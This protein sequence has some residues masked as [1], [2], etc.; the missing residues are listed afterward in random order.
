MTHRDNSDHLRRAATA[1]HDQMLDRA[2]LAVAELDRRGHPV[3]I[4]SVARAAHV[5]RSWL[6]QQGDLRD[7]IN[8]LRTANTGGRP[9]SY[10]NA[11]RLPLGTCNRSGASRVWT[12]DSTHATWCCSA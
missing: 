10:V 4:A 1:R 6:Y 9:G 11:K 12:R 5:S 2:R 8:R 7:M 3:T